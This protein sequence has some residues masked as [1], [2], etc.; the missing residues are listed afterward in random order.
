MVRL[1]K[2]CKS[3][4]FMQNH[5]KLHGYLHEWFHEFKYEAVS[6]WEK[7]EIFFFHTTLHVETFLCLHIT[8]KLVYSDSAPRTTTTNFR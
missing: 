3:P 5:E 4:V 6:F 7:T 8:Q 1:M 2:T